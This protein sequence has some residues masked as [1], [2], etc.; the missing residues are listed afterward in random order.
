MTRRLTA[1][2]L[3]A[4]A[5]IMLAACSAHPISGPVSPSGGASV[6]AGGGTA[7]STAKTSQMKMRVVNLYAPKNTVGPALDIYDVQLTGQKATPIATNVAYGSASAYFTPHLEP[8]SSLA[9]LYALPAG[10]DP[11]TDMTDAQSVGGVQDDGSHPQVTWRL[12]ADSSDAV[13]LPGPLAGLSFSEI[14]EKGTDRGS[15]G[16]VAPAPPT[17]QGGLLVDTTG[18]TNPELGL[19]LMID[20]SC[21][22]ALNGVTANGQV[23]YI[24]AVDGKAPVSDF[25]V[26]ATAPGTHQVSVVEWPSG[27]APTC[28]ELTAKQGTTSVDVTAGEQIEVYVYGTSAT[29]LHL[30]LAPLQQ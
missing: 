8:N 4:L 2:A 18:V 5:A 1:C 11:V 21:A 27:V 29:S 3:P 14:I 6:P 20:G 23:P 17:G 9:Q 28:A 30:A 25:A 26:F 7:A 22:P 24:A 12:T 13:V 15:K 16:P 10:D 19:Y